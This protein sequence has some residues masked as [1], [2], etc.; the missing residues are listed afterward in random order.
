MCYTLFILS[1]LL[2]PYNKIIDRGISEPGHGRKVVDGLIATYK[3]FIF[4][5]METV[6]LPGSK[7]FDTQMEVH[8]VTQN[9]DVSLSQKLQKHLSN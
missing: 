6:K 2:Q 5:L 3:R 8:T 9:T 4:H 1:I 7:C